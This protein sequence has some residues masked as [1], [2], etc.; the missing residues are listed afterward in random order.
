VKL[1]KGREN[2]DEIDVP[3]ISAALGA[4]N[5]DLLMDLRVKR[6]A[7]TER[8]ALPSALWPGGVPSRDQQGL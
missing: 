7:I 8:H 3:V 2:F 4:S 5:V 1:P 6:V